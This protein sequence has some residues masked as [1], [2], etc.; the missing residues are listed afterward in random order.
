MMNKRVGLGLLACLAGCGGGAPYTGPG[1]GGG[2]GGGDSGVP[3]SGA[4]G[5][6]WDV[7]HTRVGSST[8]TTYTVTVTPGS[9]AV[10]LGSTF[11]TLEPEGGGTT[12]T[13]STGVAE[14]SVITSSHGGG[15]GG[16][17]ELPI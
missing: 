15:A 8:P 7:L 12:L 5:G 10:S 11:V 3:A 2:G 17:G 16:A 14:P 1:G 9:V 4:L 13:W 6:T